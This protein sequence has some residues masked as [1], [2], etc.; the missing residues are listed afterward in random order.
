MG[1][2]GRV[3]RSHCAVIVT[4]GDAMQRRTSGAEGRW[5]SAE[6]WRRL[7]RPAPPPRR[8]RAL[9]WCS[10]CCC[11]LFAGT[12]GLRGSVRFTSCSL[13]RSSVA[14]S[15]GATSVSGENGLRTHLDGLLGLG[16]NGLR[17]WLGGGFHGGFD[18][19]GELGTLRDRGT[20]ERLLVG[21]G[22][23]R[24]SYMGDDRRDKTVSEAG[25]C[26]LLRN[27]T[28]CKLFWDVSTRQDK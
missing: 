25:G 23:I 2:R 24:G 13:F 5:W 16:H 28:T 4:D 17:G 6:E 14:L 12:A 27:E 21:S 26:K 20:E 18:C 22:A 19:G 15:P 7:T 9:C 10:W 3:G 11:L 8:R 1:K